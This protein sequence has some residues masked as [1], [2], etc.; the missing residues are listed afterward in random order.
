LL[1]AL[2]IFLW[3]SVREN[4]A[5]CPF[6]KRRYRCYARDFGLFSESVQAIEPVVRYDQQDQI[7]RRYRRVQAKIQ[8]DGLTEARI[9]KKFAFRKN[10]AI[11]VAK[12]ACQG[13]WIWQYRHNTLDAASIMY[14]NMLVDQLLA[15]FGGYAS[16]LERCTTAWNPRAS[17]RAC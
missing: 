13:M 14:L 16:L 6:S 2:V 5:R 7:L 12:R 15:S 17:W 4:R 9:G 8:E 11:S 3:L 10:L 1:P